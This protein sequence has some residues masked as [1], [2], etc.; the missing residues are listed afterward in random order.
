[1]FRALGSGGVVV[2]AGAMDSG[3]TTF[4]LALANACAV[5]DRRCAVVDGDLGQSE[6]GPPGTVGWGVLDKPAASLSDIACR[7]M[8][9]VGS[10]SPAGRLLQTVVGLRRVLSLAAAE[11][12]F[13]TIVDMPGF[14]DG[15]VARAF[16]D[17]VVASLRPAYLVLMSGKGELDPLRASL[18]GI[19]E[20]EVIALPAAE[21]ARVRSREERTARRRLK[22]GSYFSEAETI[23]LDASA[24]GLAGTSL[25]GGT[26]APMNLQLELATALRMDIV[27][28]ETAPKQ[29]LVVGNGFVPGADRR[30]LDRLSAKRVLSV[31]APAFFDNLLVGLSDERGRHR[32]MAI[33]ERVDFQTS[34]LIC[35]TPWRTGELVRQ[36]IF[37]SLRLNPDGSEVGKVD[38]AQLYLFSAARRQGGARR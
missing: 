22:F 15:P 12:P 25:F 35:R 18:R 11:D 28:A 10:T 9:F 14:V 1:M 8:F 4:C 31:V 36:V 19:M 27:H 33:L 13:L 2:V 20:P 21:H 29:L 30:E 6:I 16:L 32:A 7:D 5:Q 24:V 38:A 23:S 34:R 26:P 17:A 37:G 3:K